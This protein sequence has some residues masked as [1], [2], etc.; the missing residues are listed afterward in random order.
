MLDIKPNSYK[1]VIV[2]QTPKPPQARPVISKDLKAVLLVIKS[3][4]HKTKVRIR[5]LFYFRPKI[6]RN[7]IQSKFSICAKS[8]HR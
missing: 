8:R 4:H 5:V 1:T 7:M 6:G 3:T 2:Y